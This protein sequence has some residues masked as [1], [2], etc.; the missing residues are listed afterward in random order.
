[1]DHVAREALA[2]A[3]AEA[4]ALG[5]PLGVSISYGLPHQLPHLRAPLDCSSGTAQ[6]PQLLPA[7]DLV[8]VASRAASL[9]LFVRH[10]EAA[11]QRWGL[12][13]SSSKTE[14]MV[15]DPRRQ[16]CDAQQRMNNTRCQRCHSL[17]DGMLLCDRCDAGWHIGCLQPPLAAAPPGEWLCPPCERAAAVSSGCG[18][19]S[20]SAPVR[21]TVADQPVAWVLQFKYLGG[22]FSTDGGLA[23]EVARRMQQASYAFERLRAAVWQQRAVPLDTKLTIYHAMVSSVLLY[24]AHSWA[25]SEPQLKKL[26]TWQH[27]RLRVLLGRRTWTVPPG[28]PEPPKSISNVELH[29][30]TGTPSI[31]TQLQ[32]LRGRWLGHLLRMDDSRLA[33]QLLFGRLDTTALQATARRA[34]PTLLDTYTSDLSLMPSSKVPRDSNYHSRRNLLLLA[35]D[36]GAWN[37]FFP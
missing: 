15:L 35:A 22:M 9:Q 1:M 6:V 26:E 25:L 19:T 30:L 36:K 31:A 33:K 23:A 17:A 10:F 28:G 18:N 11:C 14:C 13:I 12:A 3:E 32:R 4:A 8:A 7:D 29:E 24:G 20:S 16:Q 5:E 21:I 34:A 27:K 37:A 2:A